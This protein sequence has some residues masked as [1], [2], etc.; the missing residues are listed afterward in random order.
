M[1]NVLFI[2][3]KYVSGRGNQKYYPYFLKRLSENLKGKNINLKYVFFSNLFRERVLTKDSF[4]YNNVRL[5]KISKK[6]IEHEA[7]NIESKY[8]FT[9]KQAYFPE[10]LQASDGHQ[11]NRHIQLPEKIISN[12]D[13]LADKFIYLEK[14]I[15]DNL[16]EIIITDQGTD[17]EMEFARAICLKNKKIFLRIQPDFMGKRTIHQE[18]GFCEDKIIEAVYDTE[19]TFDMAKGFLNDYLNKRGI[20][21]PAPVFY[22]EKKGFKDK[23]KNKLSEKG[24]IGLISAAAATSRRKMENG[25]FNIYLKIERSIKNLIIDEYDPSRQYVFWGFHL[26]TEATIAL[27]GLPY[28]RQI[29]LIESISR[30]LPF[31]VY[32]YVREHPMWRD[33]FA[34]KYLYTLSKLPNVRVI[35]T[36]IPIHTVLENSKGVV[37]YNATTGIEALMHGKPVLSFSPNVYYGL[38]TAVDYCD[39]LYKLGA[40][41]AKLV[42]TKVDREETV[43]YLHKM[44]RISNDVPLEAETFMSKDDAKNKAEKLSRHLAT[45]FQMCLKKPDNTFTH[46]K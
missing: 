31:G 23:L 17:A 3:N 2:T 24:L 4:W 45:A 9:F 14:V 40:K 21:Y 18:Y 42:N 16:F 20:P 32:L 39:N 30:V 44:F 11:F 34:F 36:K 35:S 26:T 43:R 29:S 8:E 37:T 5:K 27:R 19:F 10:M 6:E 22:S 33:M 15:K 25:L 38:H 1:I 28:L 41:L 46:L 12:L 7:K 13:H